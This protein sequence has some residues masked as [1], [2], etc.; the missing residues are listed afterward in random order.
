MAA[1]CPASLQ[2]L[3]LGCAP[4]HETET[5]AFA[6]WVTGTSRTSLRA[7]DLDAPYDAWFPEFGAWLQGLR[8]LKRLKIGDLPDDVRLPQL[9]E[10][11]IRWY[12]YTSVVDEMRK[13]PLWV[14]ELRVLWLYNISLTF[15]GHLLTLMPQL[16]CFFLAETTNSEKT[17][18]WKI[19]DE[20]LGCTCD[21]PETLV[22]MPKLRIV[23]IQHV[24]KSEDKPKWL[25]KAK[26]RNIVVAENYDEWSLDHSVY[27]E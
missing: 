1:P 9:H 11:S 23:G 2:S 26:A 21:C 13:L 27:T 25:L 4:G 12:G 16:R 14:P 7:M 10:L 18:I 3:Q 17:T 22:H 19:L 5:W 20:M 8:G 24:P 15:D 6:Q